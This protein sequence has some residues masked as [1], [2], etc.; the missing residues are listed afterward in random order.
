MMVDENFGISLAI[1][2]SGSWS[3][4]KEL[5]FSRVTLHKDGWQYLS[6]FYLNLNSQ[7][8][9]SNNKRSV[10]YNKTALVKDVKQGFC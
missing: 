4:S 3:M 6:E 9:L 1:I 2:G 7:V 5:Y 10:W 8:N